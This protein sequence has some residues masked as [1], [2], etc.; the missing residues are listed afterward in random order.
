[1]KKPDFDLRPFYQKVNYYYDRLNA[2]INSV[3]PERK[4]KNR[5]LMAF[6]A[7]LFA[8]DY[9]LFCYH[10]E[11]NPFDI[12]PIF[13]VEDQRKQINVYLPDIDGKSLIREQKKV[14][15]LKDTKSYI[16]LLFQK[17]L[18]GSEYENTSIVVPA[19]FYIRQIWVQDDI[20]SID[21][22]ASLLKKNSR[23]IP[24]SENIFMEAVS[25]TI[26]ENIPSISEVIILDKGIPGREIWDLTV[27]PEKGQKIE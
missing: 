8:A 16:Q 9:L 2:W 15:M 25:K 4:Q 5:C 13:P 26:T 27:N 18:D 21:V 12:F 7:F 10:A 11:K 1:M 17:V 14:L 20:C 24:G 19:E 6:L 3:A 22:N 23:V